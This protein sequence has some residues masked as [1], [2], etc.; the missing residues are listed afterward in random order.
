VELLER[1]NKVKGDRRERIL[2][3]IISKH[4]STD[5]PEGVKNMLERH[6]KLRQKKVQ[7]S[8][9]RSDGPLEYTFQPPKVKSVPNFRQIHEN[10]KM[11]FESMKRDFVPTQPIGF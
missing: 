8:Q 6:A 9:L 5:L 4:T 7:V 1:I 11:D 2:E 3:E 10:L